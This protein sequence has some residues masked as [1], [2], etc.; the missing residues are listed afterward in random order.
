MLTVDKYLFLLFPLQIEIEV[1]DFL[2][3]R[4]AI[5]AENVVLTSVSFSR[6]IPGLT[7]HN[8]YPT[9]PMSG[10]FMNNVRGKKWALHTNTHLSA[11]AT[12]KKRERERA[13]DKQR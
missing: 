5:F 8:A 6:S 1:V 7:V 10:L 4:I 12:A 3:V 9:L 11:Y 13:N 2:S